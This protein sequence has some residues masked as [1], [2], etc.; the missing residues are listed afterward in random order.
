LGNRLNKIKEAKQNGEI[1]KIPEIKMPGQ[2][3]RAKF[4]KGNFFNL[5]AK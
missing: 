3:S 1:L 2:Y 5:R 4:V